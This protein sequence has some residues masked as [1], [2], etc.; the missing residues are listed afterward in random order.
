M[1]GRELFKIINRYIFIVIAFK[2]VVIILSI[3][4]Q[5]FL[6]CGILR[7]FVYYKNMLKSCGSNVSIHR[8]VFIFHPENLEIGSNCS[9]HPMCYIDAEGGGRIGSNVSI[10]HAVTIMS[11]NHSW[12]DESLPIK[13]NPKVY[14]SFIID[15]DVWVGSGVRI[16][17]GVRIG[18]H[19]IIASGAVVT[20]DCDS[21][22]L[23][24][25]VPAKKIKDLA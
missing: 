25:G 1:S 7:R 17:A 8:H 15:D 14:K 20:K 5:V 10:A 16:M 3:L 24:G 9:I 12:M 23:Y 4:K 19:C 11:A 6:Y 22:G 2:P 13:Y 18:R 21:N